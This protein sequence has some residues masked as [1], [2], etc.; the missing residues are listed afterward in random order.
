[1][2]R[3]KM[4]EVVKVLTQANGTDKPQVTINKTADGS[5]TFGV[6]VTAPTIEAALYRARA[7]FSNLKRYAKQVKE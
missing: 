3:Q 1:M 5:I 7:A 6:R 4:V 2:T